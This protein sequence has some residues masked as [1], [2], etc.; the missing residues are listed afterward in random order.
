MTPQGM[1]DPEALR[2]EIRQLE[3]SLE[4]A[5][6]RVNELLQIIKLKEEL[7]RR[8]GGAGCGC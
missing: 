7:L 1:P 3:A 2:E 4:Q 6:G 8:L 5:I